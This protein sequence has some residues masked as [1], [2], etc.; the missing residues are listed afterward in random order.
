MLEL[1]CF[2]IAFLLILSLAYFNEKSKQ[3]GKMPFSIRE[4]SK[5]Q[6]QN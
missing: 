6:K 4:K 2:L 1:L 5:L 3:K